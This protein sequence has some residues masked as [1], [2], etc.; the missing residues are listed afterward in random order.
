MFVPMD[1]SNIEYISI[2]GCA[3]NRSTGN[4]MLI[5]VGCIV[6]TTSRTLASSRT[7]DIDSG[8]SPSLGIG[9]GILL[10]GGWSEAEA[11]VMLYGGTVTMLCI[12]ICIDD[13]VCLF[14]TTGFIMN[15][16]T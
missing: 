4:S 12:G 2:N 9:I 15:M 5:A 10:D 6:L 13:I 14:S 1:C 8:S 3:G 11:T 16:I 7:S